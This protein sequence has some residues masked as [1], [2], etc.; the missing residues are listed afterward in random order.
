[1]RADGTL[2][3]VEVTINGVDVPGAHIFTGFIRDVTERKAAEVERRSLEDRLHQSQRLESLGQLAGGV[4]HDFNNL[5]AV[6]LNYAT[7][8]G[9][10]VPDDDAVQFDVEQILAASQPGRGADPATAHVRPPRTGPARAPRPQRGGGEVRELLARSIGEQ[11]DLVVRPGPDLPAILADRGQTE[12]IL[13]NL[14]V[15]ARDAMP[16]G[17]I[18]TID[19]A[20]VDLDQ[21]YVQFHPGT[22][23]GPYVQLSVS[24]NGTGMSAE[25]ASRAFDPFFTTKGRTEGSGLGLA[26]VYGIV[27]EAGGAVSLYTEEGIGTTV[28]VYFAAAA[29]AGGDRRGQH[30]ARTDH[31]RR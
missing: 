21:N 14:A 12:Q 17:G 19:T 20:P 7:F 13:L 29:G 28:R 22:T 4:A 8:V 18:L 27:T 25:V 10:A 2:F 3:P 9:E 11:I 1:M 26:T 23:P 15:N 5:L 24:D 30:P 6:I 16:G 31:G